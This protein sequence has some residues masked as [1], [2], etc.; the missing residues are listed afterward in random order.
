[1]EWCSSD[2]LCIHG[3]LAMS[4]S[5]SIASCHSCTLLPET[6]CETHNQFLD[7]ALIVGTP[8]QPEIGY[9]HELTG[10]A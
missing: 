9:F 8:N 1:M 7:R 2:P 5:Y 6:S 10:G 4:D 3:E